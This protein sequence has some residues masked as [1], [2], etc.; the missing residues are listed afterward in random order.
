VKPTVS[1]ARGSSQKQLVDSL[2][3]LGKSDVLVG[4]PEDGQARRGGGPTNAMLAHLHT[5]GSPLQNIPARPIL[6]PAINYPPN[7]ALISAELG[8]AAAAAVEGNP[9]L[10]KQQLN[11]AGLVAVNAVKRWFTEPANHWAPNAP[12]T[13]ARKGSD[14]PLIDTG[15]LRASVTFIVEADALDGMAK[16]T[17]GKKRPGSAASNVGEGESA[18]EG[19]VAEAAVVL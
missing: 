8:K 6:E 4:W 16:G 18:A 17:P 19:E 14:K 15:Q 3:R 10:A 12:A 5:N 7:K 2:K 11:R 13:I 9:Q 1:I